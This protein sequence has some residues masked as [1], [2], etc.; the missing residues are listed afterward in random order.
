MAWCSLNPQS[1]LKLKLKHKIFSIKSLINLD[2]LLP[3]LA[4][5]YVAAFI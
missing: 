5:A 4:F 3:Y 1:T 2:A